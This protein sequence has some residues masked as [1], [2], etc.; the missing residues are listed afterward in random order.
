[1]KLTAEK[2][3][4]VFKLRDS[5]SER[6]DLKTQVDA[7]TD[8]KQE[9]LT[10]IRDQDDRLTAL[11]LMS[12]SL[13]AVGVNSGLLKLHAALTE[14]VPAA[15]PPADTDAD[16][17]PLSL[18]LL[19]TPVPHL[20]AYSIASPDLFVG[21]APTPEILHCAQTFS[22]Q[23]LPPKSTTTTFNLAS[24]LN[25]SLLLGT[26]Q[27]RSPPPHPDLFQLFLDS[28]SS[29]LLRVH[30]D[31]DIDDLKQRASYAHD[32]DVMFSTLTSSWSAQINADPTDTVM[33]VPERHNA[34]HTMVEFFEQA[35]NSFLVSASSESS[36]TSKVLLA[37]AHTTAGAPALMST[38]GEVVPLDDDPANHAL[39]ECVD[40]CATT[41]ASAVKMFVPIRFKLSPSAL[42]HREDRTARNCYKV[43]AV[44]VFE[45]LSDSPFTSTEQQVSPPQT[46]SQMCRGI[47]FSLARS[48]QVLEKM[49]VLLEPALSA[50]CD[51][52]DAKLSMN[53]AVG[54][55]AALRTSAESAHQTAK[56]ATNN[57][58]YLRSA[59]SS[60]GTVASRC[61][62]E[63]SLMKNE[64]L[65]CELASALAASIIQDYTPETCCS[66]LLEIESD[67]NDVYFAKDP[68]AA[69]AGSNEDSDDGDNGGDNRWVKIDEAF[70]E[71]EALTTGTGW[72]DGKG[73]APQSA[74]AHNSV[75]SAMPS[76]SAMFAHAKAQKTTQVSSISAKT[77]NG[78]CVLTLAK[79]S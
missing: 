45:R 46:T 41:H 4:L 20:D 52:H 76:H 71:Y 65:V 39:V 21:D 24:P 26:I 51:A 53:A 40:T 73:Y 6:L 42:Q 44:A 64:P 19:R 38:R 62:K 8:L 17:P 68:Q 29:A 47:I 49:S 9:H 16:I 55:I 35:T 2:E 36:P 58:L 27:L 66:Q 67:S 78:E 30:T 25:P 14:H 54:T 3:H 75:L 56:H 48:R 10:M 79:V 72:R 12:A 60:I 43:G 7:L 33:F 32:M 13:G 69:P 23:P 28:L 70:S 18:S 5:E 15:L 74:T 34:L 31:G 77:A 50:A 63:K 1:M 61:V 59:L 11:Q 57:H 22:A 37:D